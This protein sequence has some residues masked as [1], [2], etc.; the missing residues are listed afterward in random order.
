MKL[1]EIITETEF[2][3]DLLRLRASRGRPELE[4]VKK[5]SK[6]MKDPNA[7]A[8][9]LEHGFRGALK[10]DYKKATKDE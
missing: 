3:K 7:A 2:E 8:K 9:N 5:V 6:T 4:R 1:A 10:R